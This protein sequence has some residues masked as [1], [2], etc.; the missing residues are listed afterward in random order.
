MTRE[1]QIALDKT[2]L[3][4]VHDGDRYQIVTRLPHGLSNVTKKLRD[5]QHSSD[6]FG[7]IWKLIVILIYTNF[8]VSCSETHLLHFAPNS[9][10]KKMPGSKRKPF[11]LHPKP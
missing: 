3:S 2:V 11:H 8:N 1:T 9:C 6:F 10:L 5:G 4:L 7:G